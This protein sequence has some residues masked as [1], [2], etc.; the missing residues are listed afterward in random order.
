[1]VMKKYISEFIGTFALVFFG[2]GSI[3]VDS[4]FNGAVTY[5][6]IALVF[7]LVVMLLVYAFGETSGAHFNPAVSLGLCLAGDIPPAALIFYAFSQV[8]GALLASLS[9]LLIFSPGGHNLGATIPVG[10]DIQAFVIEGVLTF[11]LMLT[12][13]CVKDR[14]IAMAGFAIGAAITLDALVGGAVSG[15]SMNPARSL[16]PGV[17]SSRLEGIWIYLTAPFIGA[18]LAVISKKA[19]TGRG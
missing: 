19:V 3:I 16:G 7:G 5:L 17:V 15:A 13:L 9:L 6:G 2:T 10:T 18:V 11:F 1:M 4:L 12:I 8:S 14:G